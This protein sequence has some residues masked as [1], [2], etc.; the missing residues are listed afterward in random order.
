MPFSNN[1]RHLN[2]AGFLACVLLLAY[3]WYSQFQ[4][5]LEPCPLCIFQRVGVM[6]VGVLFLVA[7]I[8]GPRAA[9]R[10]IYGVL[11]ALAA[12]AGGAV[13]AW[14]VYLQQLPA[15]EVPA[16]GPG[17]DYMMDVFSF[18]E[19]LRM[20]FTGSGE[21]AVSDWSFLGLSMPAWVLIAFVSLGIFGLWNNWRRNR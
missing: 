10:R 9:G 1:P 4:L 21:C 8:H 5:G 6:V 19:T 13:S 11:I 14:H 18:G 12:A 3:A 17:L 2:L 16:C 7:A 15:D 20:V